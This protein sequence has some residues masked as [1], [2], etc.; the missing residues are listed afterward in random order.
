MLKNIISTAKG[1]ILVNCIISVAIFGI[2][3]FA[4]SYQH[5]RT[6]IQRHTVQPQKPP[7]P[8]ETKVQSDEDHAEILAKIQQILGDDAD[9]FAIYIFRPGTDITPILFQ[10]RPMKPASMIKMFVAAK[11]MQEIKA[12]NLSLEEELIVSPENVVGGAGSIAGFGYNAKVPARLILEHMIKESDNTATNIL[13]DRLGGMESLN[14]YLKANSY[15]DTTFQHKMMLAY[16]GLTNLSS[17]KD[18]GDLFVKIYFHKCVDDFHDKLLIEY[19][20]KQ[21]DTD[22]L[23]PALPYWRIAHKTGEVPMTYHDGGICFGLKNDFII[24]LMNDNY[25][26]RGST[27]EKMQLV[28]QYIAQKVDN[29]K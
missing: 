24:V 12:G 9:R 4:Y 6:E 11:A 22:C 15:N 28:A 23:P 26:E 13:I 10:N 1:I 14:A 19:L 2:F 18:L 29:A 3:A 21:E 25:T 27:I 16:A 20:L 5:E 7:E 8:V 17:V